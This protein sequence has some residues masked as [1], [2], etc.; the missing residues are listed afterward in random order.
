MIDGLSAIFLMLVGGL[1]GYGVGAARGFL[2]GFDDGYELC[3][4]LNRIGEKS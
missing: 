4:R 3:K 2:R 1:I